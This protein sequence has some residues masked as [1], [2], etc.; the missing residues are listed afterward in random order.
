[1]Y[2]KGACE[3]CPYRIK[4]KFLIFSNETHPL[5]FTHAHRH[6][7]RHDVR[8][9]M[10]HDARHDT[11]H[12]VVTLHLNTASWRC[13]IIQ[14]HDACHDTYH[15]AEHVWTLKGEFRL[16][17]S[18]NFFWPDTDRI[19]TLLLNILIFLFLIWKRH[20]GRYDWNFN[21]KSEFVFSAI[22]LCKT[23]YFAEK[24]NVF[25]AELVFFRY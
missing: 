19:H 20:S 3:S 18:R 2:L 17:K 16:K 15:D 24:N 9:V 13:I 10:H 1:M 5:V 8:H 6:E 14:R 25:Y 12:C 22:I 7:A 4:K 21:Q 11:H 23:W